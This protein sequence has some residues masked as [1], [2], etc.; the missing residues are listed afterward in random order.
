LA[1]DLD[2]RLFEFAAAVVI[3]LRGLPRSIE[4]KVISNQLVKSASSTGANYEEAQAAVSKQDFAYR[5]GTSLKEMRESCFWIRL[6]IATNKEKGGSTKLFPDQD[7][8]HLKT[9][10]TELKNILGS[11]YKKVSKPR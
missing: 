10:S 9:E 4:Y 2:E 7:W 3:A 5:I 6:I 1:F 8:Q 11:I